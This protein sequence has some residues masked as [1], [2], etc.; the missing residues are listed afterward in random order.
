MET[1]KLT[2]YPK[3][4]QSSR[5]AQMKLR[6]PPEN[7]PLNRIMTDQNNPRTHGCRSRKTKNPTTNAVSNVGPTAGIKFGRLE[8]V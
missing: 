5:P 1:V 7:R 6:Q 8:M 4:A 3:K 2:L